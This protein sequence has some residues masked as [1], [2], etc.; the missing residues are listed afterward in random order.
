MGRPRLHDDTT[1]EA[2]L[3]AAEHLIETG[4]PT[5]LTVRAAADEAGTTTQAVYTLFG[6]KDRLLDD[7]AQRS[8]ELLR[9]AIAALP[10]TDDPAADLVHAGLE[11]FRPM[12]IEHP[13]MFQV[14]FLR[15]APQLELSEDAWSAASQGFALLCE[16]CRRM[17]EAN[18]LGG[19]D[20]VV[21][22]SQFNALCEG[23]ATDELRN[24]NYLGPD[25]KLAWRNA[26]T[27]LTNGFRIPLQTR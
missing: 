6:S 13:S 24:P 4:G 18:L 21:A 10:T 15:A 19:R 20:P 23:L 27:T 7:L 14:A 17:A 16:R 8:F 2:L 25:P 22:A 12:A 1:R 5:A 3:A 9:D 11:V 26:L